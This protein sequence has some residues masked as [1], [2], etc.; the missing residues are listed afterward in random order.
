MY[1]PILILLKRIV[2]LFISLT[3]ATVIPE[4]N[5][6]SWSVKDNEQGEQDMNGSGKGKT[7]EVQAYLGYGLRKNGTTKYNS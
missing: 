4:K 5:E 3:P 6:A 7:R 2:K 1:Y